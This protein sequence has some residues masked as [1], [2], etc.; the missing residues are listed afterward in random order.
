MSDPE[1]NYPTGY[2]NAL[3]HN[4]SLKQSWWVGMGRRP[5]IP[6][7]GRRRQTGLYELEASLAYTA[8]SRPARATQ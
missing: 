4:Q 5:L 7:L 2:Q 1:P 8:S 3:A 6:T